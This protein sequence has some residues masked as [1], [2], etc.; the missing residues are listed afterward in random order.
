NLKLYSDMSVLLR[1]NMRNNNSNSQSPRKYVENEVTIHYR[2]PVRQEIKEALSEDELQR[3]QA[4][5][6]KKIYQEERRRKYLQVSHSLDELQDMNSRRHADNFI[7]SQKSP[8]PLNRYD[9]FLD[10]YSPKLKPRPRSPEPR[11]VAKALYNFVGQ[12]ARELTFRKGDI[13]YIRRQVDKNWYEGEHNAM[14][15]LFPANYVEIVPYDGVKS[16]IRKPHEG[17]A[18]AKYNFIAQT[19][20]ELSLAKGELVVITRRVDDNWFEGKIGGRKGIFPVSYVE[21]LIDPS[22]PPQ[23]TTPTPKPVAAPAAHSLLVNGSL[24]GKESMG[25][26][27]YVPPFHTTTD[28]S[29]S[30]HAKPVQMT[31][32]GT[33][34]SLSR[35]KNLNQAL[36]IETQSD[37]VP[38]RA[39][40]KYKPQNEDEL[41]LLEG[42]TV[43]VLEKCDD[44]WYV[45]SS[46]RTGAFGT[47]PGNYVERI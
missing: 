30:F 33:Y 36:H 26:H 19:H 25:S 9:D 20:L 17:Q 22:E 43:Y 46:E 11:L 38:Y 5:H 6:M 24:G 23:S 34:G 3:R 4:E 16:T 21:V 28:S 40:Y 13:I 47:F 15:G 8:I 10:D 2:T 31:G 39:L 14:I 18:R 29:P 7:P 41:E 37:P 1:N 32:S 45:G 27:N 42:D 44:G 35:T 12:T